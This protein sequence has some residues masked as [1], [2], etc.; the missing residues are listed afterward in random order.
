MGCSSSVA[1]KPS[2]VPNNKVIPVS[3]LLPPEKAGSFR[4]RI[5]EATKKRDII[6]FEKIL[7]GHPL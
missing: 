5:L 7:Q 2:S 3:S 6:L 4:V 1:T